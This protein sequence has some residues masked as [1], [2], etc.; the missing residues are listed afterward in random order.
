MTPALVLLLL[1]GADGALPPGH[2]AI[3][4]GGPWAP[5]GAAGLPP[6]H[7]PISG[8]AGSGQMARPTS[9]TLPPGHPAIS[10][11]SDAGQA[12]RPAVALPPGHPA[13]S[14]TGA[15]PSAHDI[16]QQLDA[17]PDL[18]TRPK[19]FEVAASVGKLYFSQGRY[20][21]AV[22][23]LRQAQQGAGALR[24][25]YLAQRRQVK[26]PLPEA[27]SAG[28]PPSDASALGAVAAAAQARAEAKDHA[29]AAACALQALQPA[30]EAAALLGNAL[31]LGADA[32]G[33]LQAY[34]W[35]L[36]VEPTQPVA[37]YGRAGVTFDTRPDDVTALRAVKKDLTEWLAHWPNLPQSPQAKALLVRT[38]E[39]LRAGGLSKYAASRPKP[40][41]VAPQAAS[42]NL[43][44]LNP[45]TV[46][47][48]QDTERTPELQKGLAELVEQGEAALAKGEYQAALDAYRRVVP[49][50]PENGRAK[51]GMAWSLVGLNRQP[52]AERVWGVA[53]EADPQAVDTLGDMLAKKGNT[54]DAQALWAKLAATSPA[55]AQKANLQKKLH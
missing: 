31:F 30:L 8:A 41:P 7:P 14:G 55:Y 4:D 49:F 13:I 5:S 46:Q 40:T 29:G 51:A 47:A 2:P 17:T 43:P 1:L 12:S 28:C 27:A 9:G 6:G 26:G 36:E 18:K 44:A 35:V 20:A 48:I 39:L 22:V 21:D 38:E 16:L 42:D 54:K 50:E 34:A 11:P 53:V 23:Y 37:L 52:M 24:T 32:A 19:P 10:S 33:A 15:A 3:S 25:L 45:E